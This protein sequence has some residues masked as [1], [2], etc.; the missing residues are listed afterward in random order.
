MEGIEGWMFTEELEWLADKAKDMDSVVE[1]GSWKG[2]STVTLCKSCPGMV[3]AIDPWRDCMDAYDEFIRNTKKTVDLIIMRMPSLR[4]V[5]LFPEK[6][7]DMVFI[8]G[9]HDYKFVKGDILAWTPVARKLICGHDYNHPD[10]PGV[11]HAVDK[12]VGDTEVYKTIWYK[13][14]S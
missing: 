3:W 4:A 7:V 14:L 13:T 1:I 5:H 8:D 10:Y 11:R 9:N 6:S 2:R 12:Y